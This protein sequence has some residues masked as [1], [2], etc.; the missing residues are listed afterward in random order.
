MGV[1]EQF[2]GHGHMPK[3]LS[4]GVETECVVRLRTVAVCL[5]SPWLAQGVGLEGNVGVAHEL[6]FHRAGEFLE[7]EIETM[8]DYGCQYNG[9]TG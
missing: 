7:T 3:W 8:V 6:P 4:V 2:E 9:G 5:V 1:A